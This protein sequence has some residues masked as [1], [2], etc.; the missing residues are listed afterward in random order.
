MHHEHLTAETVADHFEG[1][2]G[3]GEAAE[4]ER[5]LALCPECSA[6]RENLG[7]LRATL[8]SHSTVPMPASVAARIDLALAEAAEARAAAGLAT[9]GRSPSGE[10]RT[11]KRLVRPAA[12]E[13]VGGRRAGPL[14]RRRRWL[15]V[16]GGALATIAIVLGTLA[17]LPRLTSSHGEGAQ[18]ATAGEG[19]ATGQANGGKAEG[20]SPGPNASANDSGSAADGRV[21][22]SGRAYT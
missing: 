6:M 13:R 19:A 17:V 4:A 8:A 7:R 10:E 9:D 21:V 22:S 18:L 14:P 2:L 20:V 3:P 1:L 16:L 15:P 12:D 11:G 5:H